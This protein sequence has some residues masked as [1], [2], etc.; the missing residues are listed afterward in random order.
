VDK[1]QAMTLFVRI[2]ETGGMSRAAE[3]LGIPNATATTLIQKLEGSLGVKLLNRTTRRISLTADGAA[4][5]PRASAILAEIREAEETLSQRQVSPRGRVRADA[6]RAVG[7][8]PGATALLRAVPGHR[9]CA[10]VQ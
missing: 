3:T 7:D 8:H 5:Y 10:R 4:Y 1:F 9:A 6:D 2:V